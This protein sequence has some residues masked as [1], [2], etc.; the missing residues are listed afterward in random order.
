MG[1]VGRRADGAKI[2]LFGANKTTK[3]RDV[4][5]GD[6]LNI[7]DQ[8]A[9][10]WSK[11]KWGAQNYFIRTEHIVAERPDELIFLDVGQ[12]DGCIYVSA[13]TGAD[14]RIMLIDA[15][16]ADNMY[17]FL[18]WR[19]GS[20]KN[21]FRFHAAIVTHPDQDH[22]K[23]FQPVLSHEKVGFDRVYHNGI[24]ERTGNQP[25]GPSDATGRLLTDIIVSDNAM[26]TLYADPAVRG[27]KLFPRLMHTAISSPRV[28]AI[29]MLSTMH[30]EK[31][32]GQTWV[33]EFAPSSGRS[34]RIEVLGPVPDGTAAKPRLRWF[35]QTIGSTGKDDGKTKNGHSV[36][37][38]MT[39]GN[40]RVLFGGDL[41]RPA[42][43]YLL[44][45]YSG[46]A[47]GQPLSQAIAGASA[48]LGADVMKCCHHGAADVTDE[49]IKAVDPFAYV[50]SSGD[51]ESHAHPRPDLLGRL[52]KLGR[53]DAPLILC[54]EI[55]RST[56]EKG[57][58]E[59]FKKLADLDEALDGLPS[60]PEKT[61][62]KKARK[63]LQD[64]IRRRNVG[65]YG[66]ITMRSD[67]Q[68]M[69][70]SFRLE[71]P[72]GKQLWQVYAVHHDPVHGWV[73]A[74]ENGH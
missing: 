59:D 56:R 6:F 44:R 11:I 71:A 42:E 70:I 73:F 8:S 51:E 14:E 62:A 20:F 40:L 39:V 23:G 47:A 34:T 33:P 1:F 36:I 65:V 29:E 30:G 55:L 10:G 54:T 41:N 74:G 26:R 68:H 3:V 27:Q 16:V 4:R 64:H 45:H 52:G 50:V 63:A 9:D 35:G 7:V 48:R 12:G 72:R 37:L 43:D 32:G 60:G 15:G 28:G 13:E 58:E 25:L 19:F 18:N 22:Y 49:F 46:I 38:K 17:R 57:R 53:G 21:D 61:A 2:H 24:A 5:W 66:A 67:G 31:E 69:E